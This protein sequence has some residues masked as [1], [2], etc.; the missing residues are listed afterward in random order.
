MLISLSLPVL[1]L[2]GG[3][4]GIPGLN[5]L[6]GFKL[7][8]PPPPPADTLPPA[9]KPASRLALESLLLRPV[10]PPLTGPTMALKLNGHP[11]PLPVRADP[12][13]GLVAAGARS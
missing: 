11:P 2:A 4:T 9:W 6:K 5:L 3:L 13:S 7:R 10:L 1:V 12:A 8:H